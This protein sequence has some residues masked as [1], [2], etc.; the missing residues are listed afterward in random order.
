MRRNIIDTTLREG[1]Q[2]PGVIFTLEQ[3]KKI[4]N[5]LARIGVA[6]VEA[7]ISS[8][9]VPCLRPLIKYCREVHPSVRLSLWSRC[10][11]ED[12]EYG[13]T[14]APD[15]IS[16]S[17]P[18]SDLHL[19]K[20]IGKDRDWARKAVA[21]GIMLARHLGMAVSVGFEDATRADRGFLVEMA[22][23]AEHSGAARL[24]IA[25]TVGTASPQEIS[26]LISSIG[27]SVSS[28]ELGVHTHNDFGMATANAIAAFEAGALW[29]DGAV[30]GLGE[31]A[32]C[33]RLEELAGYLALVKGDPDLHVEHLK[34]LAAF[35]A[36]IS[37]KRIEAQ[38]PVLGEAIF[39]CETGLHLQG[40]L[41]DP[42]TY[43]PYGPE[44]VGAERKLLFGSKSGTS[45]HR[46]LSRLQDSGAD[47][48]AMADQLIESELP[49]PAPDHCLL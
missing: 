39:T 20:K 5:Y 4:V 9:R 42:R 19:G 1:E 12:I 15:I 33:A 16:L 22:V 24:R 23:L 40:L 26:E 25:D 21:E 43:E 17:I 44:R 27:S 30:L 13:A 6:E 45:A 8:P 7:G 11:Q 48:S 3:K 41:V 31:R 47:Q 37:G 46:R 49:V 38:H 28:C 14:L 29:A 32:G 34:P 36:T 35:V 18:V 2:T 10:R